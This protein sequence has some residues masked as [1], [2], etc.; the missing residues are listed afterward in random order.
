MWFFH[1]PT[2]EAIRGFLTCQGKEP[3][4]YAEVGASRAVPPL[5]YVVDHRRICL[6]KGK[7]TFE[8]ARNALRR[9]EMFSTDWVQLCWPE[10]PIEAGAVVGVLA[11]WGSLWC[12]NACRIVYALDETEPVRKVGF[13]YGTLP[14]HVERGEERFTVEWRDD[15]SVW[16][17]LFAFS[18]PGHWLVRLGHPLARRLQKRFGVDALAAMQRAVRSL[19]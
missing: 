1:K 8:A 19:S 13:A 14:D 10:T 16:Y 18:R 3:F 17:D 12:L 2:P 4:S 15:D 6:G 9:W 11:H 7:A 5:G